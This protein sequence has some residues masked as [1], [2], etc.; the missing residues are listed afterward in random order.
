MILR[1][2]EKGI[3]MDAFDRQNFQFLPKEQRPI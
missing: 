3:S 1:Q 2:V